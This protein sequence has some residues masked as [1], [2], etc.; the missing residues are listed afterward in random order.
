MYSSSIFNPAAIINSLG[1]AISLFPLPI[2]ASSDGYCRNNQQKPTVS[3]KNGT[4]EGIFSPG[5]HQDFFLG[6]PY[7]K[8]PQRFSPPQP[9]DEGWDTIRPATSYPPHCFGYGSF[10]IGYNMS[11]D[12][13]YLNIIRPHGLAQDAKLPVAFYIH[14]GGLVGRLLSHFLPLAK[15]LSEQ[16]TNST[17]Y[18]GGSADKRFNLSFIVEQSVQMKKP[19]I[20][21]SLN[22]RLGAWGFL[23]SKEALDAGA[24]NIGFRDQ[25]MALHWVNENIHAFGGSPDKVTIWGGSS[26]AESVT[27]QVLAH[28]GAYP[29]IYFGV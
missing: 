3:V 13:L 22:Y 1:Y 11:E 26:G 18:Q 5:Y 16:R 27:A 28:N 19:I 21:V 17:Q 4:Y 29:P 20:G 7:A 9:L 8:K 12:C 14:G 2:L 10:N 6:I 24:T 23:G 15:R 25:R